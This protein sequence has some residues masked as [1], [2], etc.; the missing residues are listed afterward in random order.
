MTSMN[1]ELTNRISLRSQLANRRRIKS[2]ISPFRKYYFSVTGPLHLLPDYLIIGAAKCGTSS[3]YEYLVRHPNVDSGVGKEIYFFDLNY[4]KGTNWYRT[5]FPFSFQRTISKIFA[6]KFVVGE[7]TPRYLDH[8]YA[9][10][11]IKKII[12]NVKLIILLR[13]PI[14]RAY[15]HWNMMV[16]HKRENFSFEDAIKNEKKRI[17]GLF[18]KME[19]DESYYSREY[20]W[21]G[22]LDRGIYVKKIKKW[23]EI[24]PKNQFL[25]LKSED[26][27]TDPSEIFKRT[28]KFLDIPISNLSEYG[29]FRKGVYKNSS[30]EPK[31]RKELNE[32]FQPYNDELYKLIGQNFAWEE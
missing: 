4:N 21:Y 9:P 32:F 5:F 28:Q 10:Q 18:E 26:L 20:Y 7:A 12:P 29:S 25:I 6:E 22:Y 27:F 16:G 2:M 17:S 15:S 19:K 23:M 31:T 3:L 1:D 11:R 24:F 14:D 13:N 8:P 30:M